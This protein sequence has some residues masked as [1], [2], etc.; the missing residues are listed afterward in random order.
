M[1][2]FLPTAV[3]AFATGWLGYD[4]WHYRRRLTALRRNCWFRNE[5]QHFV[6]YVNASDECRARAESTKE[7]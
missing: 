2:T 3:F 1:L 4:A 5:R 7:T 6:R